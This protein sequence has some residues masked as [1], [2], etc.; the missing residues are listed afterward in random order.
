M[1]QRPSKYPLIFKTPFRH[2][3]GETVLVL[4]VV[5]VVLVFCLLMSF[6]CGYAAGSVVSNDDWSWVV[7][8]ALA[9]PMFL[10]LCYLTWLGARQ[11]LKFTLKIGPEELLFGKGLFRESMPCT[12]VE[13]IRDKASAVHDP[14]SHWVEITG[15]RRKWKCFFGHASGACIG[16]LREVCSN[17]VFVDIQ[18]KEHLPAGT[19]SPVRAIGNLVRTRRATATAALLVA[20][21][22]LAWALIILVALIVK[23]AQGTSLTE[24][25]SGIPVRFLV[26]PVLGTVTLI[27]AIVQF[28]RASQLAGRLK[29]LSADEIE[30][31]VSEKPVD[32]SKSG[33]EDL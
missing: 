20:I 23:V 31:V 5:P 15:A 24:A 19:H 12:A 21:P 11:R 22:C 4:V 27:A 30:D 8:F 10:V 9:I 6:V 16:A 29:E 14:D 1:E 17:A 2:V 25:V 3:L 18:G 26:V 13:T 32:L 7:L 33:F 28:R